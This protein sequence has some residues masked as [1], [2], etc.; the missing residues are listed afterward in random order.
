MTFYEPRLPCDA[1]QIGRFRAAIGEAGVEELLKA[2]IDTAVQ[3][4]AIAHPVDSRLLEIARHKVVAAAKRAGIALKQTF[5]RKGKTLRRKAGGYAHAKQ[6]K[7]LRKVVKRQRTILGIVLREVGRKIEQASEAS[8]LTLNNLRT[9]MQRAE[10]IRSQRPKDKNKLYALHAPEVECIGKGKAR[11]PYEFGVKVSV[12]IA[13]KRGL[14]VGAR[15][16]AGNPYEG[17]TLAEQLEQVTILTE[18]T[19][20][21]SKQVTVD[22]GFGAWTRPTRAPRSSTG[23]SSRA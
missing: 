14:M 13:H 4:K 7:R 1:T 21:K 2:S 12:A 11:K 10:R 3:S 8:A 19:G 6:F 18:D 23:A 5:V 22:L 9:L 20:T 15:S 16:F 17:H